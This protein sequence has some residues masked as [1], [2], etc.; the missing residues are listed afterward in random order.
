[1]VLAQVWACL[2]IA[3]VLQAIRI[4]VA[5]RAEVDAFEVSLSLL[6]EVL[7]QFGLQGPD[8]I[9]QC[10]RQ[11]RRLGIIRPSTRLSI[12]APDIPLEQLIPLPKDAILC[13]QPSYSHKKSSEKSMS[14]EIEVHPQRDQLVAILMQREAQIAAK[15]LIAKN[16]PIA[17]SEV[18]PIKAQTKSR[19]VPS[20]QAVTRIAPVVQPDSSIAHPLWPFLKP[21]FAEALIDKM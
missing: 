15:A 10:V 11:G 9:A 20:P 21:L 12:E 4:E 19:D 1:M 14:Q 17:Q 7:P 16:K 2:I 6:I 18:G 8:G 5:L 13:R 3:Q